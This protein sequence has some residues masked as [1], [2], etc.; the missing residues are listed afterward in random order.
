MNKSNSLSPEKPGS[1]PVAVP[2]STVI[3]ARNGKQGVEIFMVLR[4]HQID[5]ASGALVFPGGKVE[6]RD[7]DS[8]FMEVSN[9]QLDPGLKPCY[10]IAAIRETYEESGILLAMEPDGSEITAERLN[11]LFHYRKKLENNN[12]GLYEFLKK[13]NLVADTR[14]L[15]SYAHWITPIVMPKRFDT[16]FFLVKAPE[17]QIGKHDGS[18]SVDSLWITPKQALLDYEQGKRTIV[19]PTRM[20]IRKLLPFDTVEQVMETVKKEKLETICP[21][22]EDRKEGQFLCIPK[23]AGYG[24]SEISVE[25]LLK[26]GG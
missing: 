17:G 21:W 1:P 15:V 5:F 12:I 9:S 4:H 7:L 18:E 6:E 25:Q 23:E 24:I 8:R 26:N 19:F 14:S 10:L 13:E 16:H 3:L 20:N 22:I 11:T 2:A